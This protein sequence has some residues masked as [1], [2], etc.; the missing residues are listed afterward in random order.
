MDV[1]KVKFSI[2]SLMW[3]RVVTKMV[4]VEHNAAFRHLNM[5]NCV[6]LICMWSQASGSFVKKVYRHPWQQLMPQAVKQ[7][8]VA[9]I[10]CALPYQA[11]KYKKKRMILVHY[12]YFNL[13]RG[14]ISFSCFSHLQEKE[15]NSFKWHNYCCLLKRLILQ[16]QAE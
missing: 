4:S 14:V 15:G 10:C 9:A 8:G 7:N 13:N 5:R 6:N 3:Y 11:R 1:S 12:S 2:G 16:K